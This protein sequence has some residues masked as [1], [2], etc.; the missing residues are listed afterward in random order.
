MHGESNPL[1]NIL[2]K[3]CLIKKKVTNITDVFIIK[4]CTELNNNISKKTAFI[5]R[6]L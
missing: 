5:R 1:K 4:S 2:T 6:C 3:D